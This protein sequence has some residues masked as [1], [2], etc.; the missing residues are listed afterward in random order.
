MP[1]CAAAQSITIRIRDQGGGI[2]P[3]VLPHIWAF[4]F[5]TFSNGQP[6]NADND[7]IDALNAISGSGGGNASSIAGLGYGLPLSRAY[8][9]Y[10]G[11]GISVESLYGFGTDVYLS[12]QGVGK[13]S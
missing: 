11:G 1:M 2:P 8:A 5:T 7:N 13:I 6:S 12:L 4:N 9:E 3:E 10:F